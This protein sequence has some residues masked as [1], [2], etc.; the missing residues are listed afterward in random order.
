[1]TERGTDTV[2][3]LNQ[4][5]PIGTDLPDPTGIGFIEAWIATLPPPT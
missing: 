5:P 4:M 2:P 1:M 3:N